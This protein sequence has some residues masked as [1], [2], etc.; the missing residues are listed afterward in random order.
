MELVALVDL[1]V[2]R[3]C[4][5]LGN[6]IL[7][8][9]SWMS[10][11]VGRQDLVMKKDGMDRWVF[12]CGVIGWHAF[13]SINAR[14]LA[15]SPTGMR[16]FTIDMDNMS[17]PED[18]DIHIVDGF[19]QLEGSTHKVAVTSGAGVKRHGSKSCMHHVGGGG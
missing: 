9:K 13:H 19:V 17:T 7:A 16:R 8:Q 18:I 1:Y 3:E 15:P 4:D 6:F 2:L 11:L 5:H 10:A 14:A 12:A